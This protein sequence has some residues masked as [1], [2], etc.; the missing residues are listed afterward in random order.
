MPRFNKADLRHIEDLFID[1]DYLEEEE[2]NNGDAERTSG[3]DA[4]A[5]CSERIKTRS[6]TTG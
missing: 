6:S 4:N 3:Q 2:D 5:S 1:H